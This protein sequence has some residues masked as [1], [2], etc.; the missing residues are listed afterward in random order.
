MRRQAGMT[1]L[2]MLVLVT[3]IGMFAFGFIRLTPV[4]LNYM[5]VAGVVEGVREEFDGQG[6]SRAAIRQSIERRFNVE[7]VSEIS[8]RDDKVTSVDGA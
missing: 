3:F 8:P 5:K 6:P 7:S 1:T 2:G 4:Y